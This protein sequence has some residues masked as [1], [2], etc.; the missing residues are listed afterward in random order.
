VPK[1][2]SK[3]PIAGV[4]WAS[5][6][7][8]AAALLVALAV[9][10]TAEPDGGGSAAPVGT[11]VATTATTAPPDD[12]LSSLITVPPGFVAPD[13]RGVALPPVTAKP[14]PGPEID[15]TLPLLPMQGGT[16]KIVGTVFGPDGPVEGARV[17]L[18]RWV[19]FDHGQLDVDTNKDGF[20]VA[21]E[22]LGGRYRVRAWVTDAS[23]ATVTPQLAFLP[24]DKTERVVDVTVERHDGLLL[25]G[26]L[27]RA[28]PHVD[29][30]SVLITLLAQEYVDEEGIVRGRGVPDAVLVA[31][32]SLGAKVDGD[33]YGVTNVDG[34]VLFGVAC[35][36][37]D[38]PTVSLESSGLAT[39]VTLPECKPA[40]P[41]ETTTTTT[42]TTTTPVPTT[43][44]P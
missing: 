30:P 40:V 26:A 34:F 29:E 35:T 19:G 33:G 16:S 6:L 11:G 36:G 10:C 28:E 43:R 3:D 42:T 12:Q 39:T 9:A 44:K 18:E 38:V 23:L 7:V 27:D 2:W 17:R 1:A 37:L 41:V 14:K 22:L 25:Q 31:R 32:A 4:R 24:A 20:F 21:D 8:L 15:H 13:G 5:G